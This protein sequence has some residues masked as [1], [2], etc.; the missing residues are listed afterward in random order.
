MS[1]QQNTSTRAPFAALAI[2]AAA[3]LWGTVGVATRALYGLAPGATALSIGFFRLAFS[4]PVLALGAWRVLGPALF[5]VA[6]RDLAL[7]LVMGLMMALYQVCYFAAIPLLGVSTT[8]II[9]ICSAPVL[10]AL[11][12]AQFLKEPFTRRMALV[13]AAAL[14]G[15][16]LLS[17]LSPADLGQHGQAL[18]GVLLALG[19]AAGYAVLALCSRALAGRYHPLHPIVVA[20]SFGAVLL[21]PFALAGG[22][23][24]RYPPAGWLLLL[25]LGLVPTALAYGLFLR[26]LQR[27]PATVASVIGLIEPLTSTL[28][29]IW[30]FGERIQ[31]AGLAGAGL[32]IGALFVLPRR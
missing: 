18:I 2:L 30:L 17:G 21:L 13:L 9:T 10:V 22:L 11:L 20:F 19:S 15:T 12:A 27:T 14:S 25:Y 26:G 16:V 8:A 32:L 29:A 24:V 6:R 23:E 3:S 31:P 1:D 5:R 4:A 28:L 7:M